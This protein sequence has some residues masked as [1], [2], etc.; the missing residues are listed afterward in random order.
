M[1]WSPHNRL[2][3]RAERL[4]QRAD[5]MMTVHLQGLEDRFFQDRT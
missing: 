2:E 3:A 4:E 5:A 1:H